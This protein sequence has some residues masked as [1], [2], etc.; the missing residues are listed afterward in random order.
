[1]NRQLTL[2]DGK[3]WRDGVEIS[4]RIGDAEQIALL[5]KEERRIEEMEEYGIS[6]HTEAAAVRI[7]C[8]FDCICGS[9]VEKEVMRYGVEGDLEGMIDDEIAECLCCH[10][11]YKFE[12][13][14]AKL[15]QE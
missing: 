9:M 14:Y 1:M 8:D 4:P 15:M 13:G 7:E 2:K 11:K 5:K 3:F 6:I 12:G 10:R